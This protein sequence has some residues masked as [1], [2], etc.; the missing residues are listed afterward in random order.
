VT[1][2]I[3]SNGQEIELPPHDE[4]YAQLIAR[5]QGLI[6]DEEQARLRTANLLIAGCGS[7]GGA[8]IEPLVRMGAEH[9]VGEMRPERPGRGRYPSAERT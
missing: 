1:R 6:S 4:F 8:V 9:L 5:N 7:I 2:F 3:L